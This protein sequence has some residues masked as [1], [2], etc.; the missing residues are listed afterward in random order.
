MC[1]RWAIFVAIVACPVTSVVGDF[2]T[3]SACHVCKIS[4]CCVCIIS[5]AVDVTQ[6]P[7]NGV[8]LGNS[9]IEWN[10]VINKEDTKA[11]IR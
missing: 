11:K 3:Q 4:E 1:G 7:R 9:K 8:L 5:R 2:L 6:L 10:E